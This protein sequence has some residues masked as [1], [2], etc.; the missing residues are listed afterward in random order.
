MTT[1]GALSF[2]TTH[3]MVNRVHGNTADMRPSALPSV[4]ARFA[5][6]LTVVFAVANGTD[7][8]A[9]EFME[10]AHLAG[11]KTNQ[12]VFTFFGHEL[13]RGSGTAHELGAFADFHFDVVNNRTEG[14]VDH[15]QAVTRLNV[16]IVAGYHCI[17]HGNA[18]R[19]EYVALLAIEIAEQRDVGGSVRIVF[20]GDDFRID[21][22]LVTLEIDE[23]ILALMTTANVTGR[24]PSVVVPSAGLRQAYHQTFLRTLA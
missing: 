24:N 22:G 15:R 3:W 16:H 2:T 1:A 6:L 18:V 5:E 12:N 8:G 17:A 7:A 13:G 21:T 20:D 14:D 11:R 9:A 4:A 19:G 23:T 10:L